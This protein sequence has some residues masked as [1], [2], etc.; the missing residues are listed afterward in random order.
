M[1]KSPSEKAADA[2]LTDTQLA[3]RWQISRWQFNALRRAG[4]LPPYFMV[5]SRRRYRLAD[6]EAHEKARP[7]DGG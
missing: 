6:I 4:K 7:S 5:G 1:T 3:A 2:A